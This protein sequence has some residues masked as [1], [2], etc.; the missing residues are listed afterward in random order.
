M[1][2]LTLGIVALTAVA[3]LAGCS[4]G[5]RHAKVDAA[6]LQRVAQ[7][8]ARGED[9]VSPKEVAK[10]IVAGRK[11]FILIDVRKP[12]AYKAA[13]IK[14]ATNIPMAELMN[15]GRLDKLPPGRKLIVYSANSADASAAVALLRITGRNA[16]G[17]D[18]GYTA[19]DRDVL[20]PNIPVLASTH[21]A[22]AMAKKRALAC[23]FVGGKRP[24][25]QIPVYAP[26]APPPVMVPAPAPHGHEGC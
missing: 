21:E 23:Y 16:V 3:A 9:W 26:E 6:T 11:D 24:S 7:D 12:D 4:P 17:L 8:V 1:K 19:W 22:P 10:S 14:G 2:T 15:E 25:Q 18:G 20:H 13:H 5:G